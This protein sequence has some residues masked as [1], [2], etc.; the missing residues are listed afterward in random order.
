MNTIELPFCILKIL[1]YNQAE[2]MVNE[3]VIIDEFK[4]CQLSDLLL[5]HL[6]TPFSLLIN[7]KNSYTYTFNAQKL[8]SKICGNGAVAVL[9]YTSGGVLSTETL[10]NVNRGANWNINLFYNRQDALN[11]LEE[12]ELYHK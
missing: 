7:K 5:T 11:W 1:K 4:V 6:K 12:P 3:G 8:I 9:V 10:I 2:I